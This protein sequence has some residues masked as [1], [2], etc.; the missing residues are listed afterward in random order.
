METDDLGSFLKQ[1]CM[2][3]PKNFPY[4]L[5]RIC[6]VFGLLFIYLVFFYARD[7]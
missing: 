1:G 6:M 2:V 7:S 5:I 3:S 4:D